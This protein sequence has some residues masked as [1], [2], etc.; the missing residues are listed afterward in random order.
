MPAKVGHTVIKFHDDVVQ[1][2]HLFSAKFV[3]FC[4]TCCNLLL[5]GS[6]MRYLLVVVDQ[7][8][9]KGKVFALL[10]DHLLKDDGAVKTSALNATLTSK[11][12]RI[13]SQETQHGFHCTGVFIYFAHMKKLRGS[14]FS[15]TESSK[16]INCTEYN[17]HS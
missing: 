14:F 11:K 15:Y 8:D 7:T 16:K 10:W 6:Q 2:A 13:I 17:F 1:S 9:W 3:D 4:G 5:A 12:E